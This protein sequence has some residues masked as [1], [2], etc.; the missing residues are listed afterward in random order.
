MEKATHNVKPLL[1]LWLIISAILIFS[2]RDV[3]INR[4]GWDPDDQL[5]LVQL[6][7]FLGGQSWFDTN[8]YR[9]NPPYGAPMH[10]SRLI[11]LPLALVV[12]ITRPFFGQTIAEMIA[13][14]LV[15]LITLGLLAY[16]LGRIA[17]RLGD[18]KAG[19][20]AIF[21]TL[22]STALLPQMQPMR[23][24]HH[25]WQIL[26]AAVALWTMF[27]A[28]KKRSGVVLGL[29][30]ATWM[31]I[32]LEGL[33]AA[34]AFFFLLA[35][36]W[37]SDK[38]SGQHLLWTIGSFVTASL[39]LF[40]ATQRHPFTALPYCDTISPPY[41]VA[42]MLAGA[43]MIAAILA[44]PSHR[45][46][47][48]AATG[49]AGATAI[50][51]I[52]LIA[53]QCAHG[54]FGNLDPLVR[55][56]WYVHINEG[57]PVWHQPLRDALIWLAP[58]LCGVPALLALRAR[59]ADGEA[60]QD[61]AITGYFLLYALVISLLVFRTVS[62]AAA[63][64]IPLV[65]A[66]IRTLFAAYRQSEIPA[67]RVALVA[68]ML[69]L[70]VPGA[71]VAQFVTSAEN[72]IGKTQSAKEIA[73]DVATEKCESAVS[74]KALATIPATNFIAPFDIGP[75][76]LLTTPHKVLASSHHR[77]AQGMHD[78]IE[79]FRSP[80]AVALALL[81]AHDIQ[82]IAACPGEAEL[83]YYA[84]QDPSGLWALLAAGKA[85]RWI[86]PMP[87]MGKG[88]KVWRVRSR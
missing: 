43:I 36:R 7:D 71:F 39:L 11:E 32:S 42:I 46:W 65:A 79:I 69:F 50:A 70:L 13:G 4:S 53:P 44:S 78:H 48:I 35:W 22:T 8:Q 49:V 3:I 63:F 72:V 62:V 21:L 2:A 66:W 60:S 25:G 12:L 9:L 28:D 15:P 34:A 33:P 88:I 58:P 37:I 87:D 84:K 27:G 82:F 31:H 56:Y 74:V 30:L 10:W 77:N 1:I 68:V 29:A 76:I 52:L 24:D 81:K 40:L 55:E 6:R 86:E 54:A 61:L 41:L 80:P 64:A 14:T 67:R 75:T 73:T 16:I 17:T 51:A 83:E 59:T 5:R 45:S 26:L 19:V 20:I 85:P 47:R 18:A 38:A 57:L 23:I